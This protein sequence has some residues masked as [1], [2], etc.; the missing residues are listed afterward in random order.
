MNNPPTALVGLLFGGTQ[1]KTYVVGAGVS[2]SV[3]Y[4]LGGELFDK[5]DD[6][7]RR[8][9]NWSHR[10]DYGKEWPALHDWLDTNINP[11]I[12]EAYRRRQLEHLF[13]VLDL[14]SKMNLDNFGEIA[15]S[16]VEKRSDAL[17]SQAE[18]EFFEFKV[19]S[20][21]D[22][23]LYDIKAENSEFDDSTKDYR[24]Y[25]ALLLLRWRATSTPCT[26]EIASLQSMGGTS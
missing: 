21:Q 22:P 8:M 7:V 5:L 1:V 13:T 12:K 16:V 3:G 4:P 6:F 20:S 14:A 18:A 11:L 24:H 9:G 15:R 17:R 19:G 23:I 10:F 25:R 26:I 2:H